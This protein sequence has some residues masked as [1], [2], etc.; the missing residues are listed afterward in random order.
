M[1]VQSLL[2]QCSQLTV[3]RLI[4]VHQYMVEAVIMGA[5]AKKMVKIPLW[6]PLTHAE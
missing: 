1:L 5:A 2:F 3:A 4:R 6:M